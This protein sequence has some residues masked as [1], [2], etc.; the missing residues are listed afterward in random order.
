MTPDLANFSDQVQGGALLR[1]MDQAAYACASRY[2]SS[3]V[4]TTCVDQTNF[5]DVVR[6]GELVT[7]LASVNYTDASS[8]EVGVKL[9]AEDFRTQM[10]RHVTSCFF[11]LSAV[12]EYQVPMLIHP[13]RLASPDELRRYKAAQARRKLR[14][15][16]AELYA[17][18]HEGEALAAA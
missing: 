16:V 13:L 5:R 12:D 15:E 7:L 10:V 9:V 4:T 14:H 2:T 11:T 3:Y 17:R 1:L 6:V 8:L 18:L